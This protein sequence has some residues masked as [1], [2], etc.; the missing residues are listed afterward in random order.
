MDK[1][2]EL[3]SAEIKPFPYESFGQILKVSSSLSPDIFPHKAVI[4]VR[5]AFFR[6]MTHKLLEGEG[7]GW[8][9][10]IEHTGAVAANDLG[11]LMLSKKIFDGDFHYSLTKISQPKFQEYVNTLRFSPMPVGWR[12]F[13]IAHSHPVFDVINNVGLAFFRDIPTVDRI[14][15]TWSG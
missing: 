2:T 3:L 13:G 4:P 12:I 10:A 7:K 6:N 8:G 11:E 9:S 14:P 1:G 5:S 15:V